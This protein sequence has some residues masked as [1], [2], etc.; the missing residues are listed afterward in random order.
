MCM[1]NVLFASLLPLSHLLLCRPTP[2]ELLKHKMFAKLVEDM[3]NEVVNNSCSCC[4]ACRSP[5][6]AS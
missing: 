6:D 1:V 3:A 4:T 2:E 5:Y